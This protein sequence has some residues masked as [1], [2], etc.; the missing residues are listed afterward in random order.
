MY[1]RHIQITFWKYHYL[2]FDG[3]KKMEG[4]VQLGQ[5]K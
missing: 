4:G 2:I 3:V 5:L 1:H